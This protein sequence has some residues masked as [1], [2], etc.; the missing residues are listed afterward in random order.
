M[1][2]SRRSGSSGNPAS[3]AA[4]RITALPSS[5]QIAG[6]VMHQRTSRSAYFIPLISAIASSRISF[7]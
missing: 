3:T 2:S 1:A 7:R 5:S 6:T 4:R